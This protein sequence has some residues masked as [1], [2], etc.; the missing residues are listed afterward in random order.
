M[1]IISKV[2][3]SFKQQ[4]P[5]STPKL[6]ESKYIENEDF[7]SKKEIRSITKTLKSRSRSQ[8]PTP[9]K[10]TLANSTSTTISTITPKNGNHNSHSRN[11][12]ITF[13]GGEI[14]EDFGLPPINKL[15][16]VDYLQRFEVIRYL[17]A[18]NIYHDGKSN[19][20]ELRNILK[21]NL[22]LKRRSFFSF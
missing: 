18:F 14:P 17:D 4:P 12:S 11:S 13:P 1:N 19:E 5:L 15:N 10:D 2:R 16:D 7:K 3:L 9:L 8:S 6:N 22:N 21:D 20:E